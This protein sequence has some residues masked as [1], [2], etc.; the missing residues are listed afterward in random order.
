MRDWFKRAGLENIEYGSMVFFPSSTKWKELALSLEV[1]AQIPIIKYFG[2]NVLVKG[3]KKMEAVGAGTGA[4]Q[5]E[6]SS[7]AGE[8]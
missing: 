4:G 2:R 3:K 8:L 5:G 7:I 1:A 6:P